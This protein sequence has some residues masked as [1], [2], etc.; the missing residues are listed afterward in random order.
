MAN[1]QKET[2]GMM[3][4][5]PPLLEEL[6]RMIEESRRSL[7]GAVNAAMTMLYWRIGTRI[8]ATLSQQLSWSQ[9]GEIIPLEKSL[10][11]DFY[12]EMCRIEH[13]RTQGSARSIGKLLKE[14]K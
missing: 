11:R 13:W 7:A 2:A 6:R 3:R 1:K 4:L 9:F 12:S 10:Q 5:S 14:G 8:V